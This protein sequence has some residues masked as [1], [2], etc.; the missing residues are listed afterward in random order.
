MPVQPSWSTRNARATPW[1]PSA[2]PWHLRVENSPGPRRRRAGGNGPVATGGCAVLALAHFQIGGVERTV[3]VRAL[4]AAAGDVV[5]GGAQSV[6]QVSRFL[7][8][9]LLPHPCGQATDNG[10]GK[11]GARPAHP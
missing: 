9:I 4:G 8:G 11:R 3:G 7:R 5:C 2:C 6:H 10:G 1:G